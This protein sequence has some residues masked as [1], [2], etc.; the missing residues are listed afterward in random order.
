MAETLSPP[1]PALRKIPHEPLH[2]RHQI[3]LGPLEQQVEMVPHHHPGVHPPTVAAADLATIAYIL[4]PVQTNE[5]GLVSKGGYAN[6]PLLQKPRLF[7]RFGELL[8][9]KLS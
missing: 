9:R 7:L 8:R 4:S 5:A 6:R 2:S 1:V 3:R